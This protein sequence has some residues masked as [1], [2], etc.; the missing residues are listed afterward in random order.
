MAKVRS[1]DKL[2]AR[3]GYRFVNPALLD[4]ALTHSSSLPPSKRTEGSYQRLEFLGDRVLGLVV[5]ELLWRQY[6]KASEGE[7][8]RAH[9][10]LVRAESCARIAGLLELGSELNLGDSERKSGGAENSA[11]LA[12]ACEALFGAIYADG[13]FEVAHQVVSNLVSD[14]VDIAAKS[15]AS[16][17]T[18]LQEWS[19]SRG[20]GL[21]VYREVE[22]T[23]PDH[24][25][26]F[27]ISVEVRGL[28]AM[29]ATGPTKKL[30]EQKAAEAF[31]IR[32]KVW[33]EAL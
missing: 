15:R 30:A 8:H 31:L 23:G 3:L 22:R 29:M 16:A 26:D 6:P 4:R 32:E 2:Q 13:G 25:P 1:H 5:A 9:A 19:D 21:P 28:E 10:N 24:A 18:V 27:T 11:I 20:L 12:D 7:L 17:K 14:R 33:R